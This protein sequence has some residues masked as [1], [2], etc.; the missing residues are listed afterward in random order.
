MNCFVFVFIDTFHVPE[1]LEKTALFIC[2]IIDHNVY[3]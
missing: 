3:H 1:S 2:V